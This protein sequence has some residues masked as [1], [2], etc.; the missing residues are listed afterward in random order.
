MAK[1]IN[2]AVS[3]SLLAGL[4]EEHHKRATLTS[5]KPK[6]EKRSKCLKIFKVLFI[7]HN[8]LLTPI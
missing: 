5:V 7:V 8:V 1:N 4:G 2:L 3:Q 6:C